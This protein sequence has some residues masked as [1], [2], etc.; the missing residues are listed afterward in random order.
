MSFFLNI[1]LEIISS[2]NRDKSEFLT[3]ME[4]GIYDNISISEDRMER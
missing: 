3:Q 2:A 1:E 4:S